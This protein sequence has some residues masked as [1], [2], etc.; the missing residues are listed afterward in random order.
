M[1]PRL[2]SRAH[3][4]CYKGI[5]FRKVTMGEGWKRESRRSREAAAEAQSGFSLPW[6]WEDGRSGNPGRSPGNAV[7]ICTPSLVHQDSIRLG[8]SLETTD[9]VRTL[10]LTS[11]CHRSKRAPRSKLKRG[12]QTIRPYISTSPSLSLISASPSHVL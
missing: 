8:L 2:M 7:S 1:D 9:K 6:R 4:P 10:L 11:N 12:G 3:A 5:R